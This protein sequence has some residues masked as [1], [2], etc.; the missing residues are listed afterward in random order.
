MEER[1]VYSCEIIEEDNTALIELVKQLR[2]QNEKLVTENR[3]LTTV[4]RKAYDELLEWAQCGTDKEFD[5]LMQ[6]ILDTLEKAKGIGR[7]QVK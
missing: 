2:K 7:C 4:L 5:Y 1:T 3:E 6:D